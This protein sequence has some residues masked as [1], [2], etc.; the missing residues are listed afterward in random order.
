M[1]TVSKTNNDKFHFDKI[2]IVFEFFI[3]LQ[4]VNFTLNWNIFFVL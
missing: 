2:R 4:D 1:L 3:V